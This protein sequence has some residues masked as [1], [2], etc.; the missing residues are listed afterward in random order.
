MTTNKAQNH[1][2]KV[3]VAFDPMNEWMNITWPSKGWFTLDIST[4]IN[5]SMKT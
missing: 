3:P 5:I 1:K 2:I 4:N